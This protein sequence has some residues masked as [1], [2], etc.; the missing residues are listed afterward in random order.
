MAPV[1]FL[2]N[3]SY[4]G[5]RLNVSFISDRLMYTWYYLTGND[6]EGMHQLIARVS[7]GITS[8]SHDPLGVAEM[9]T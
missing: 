9:I 6:I 5:I 1:L 3:V 4:I 7:E 2:F 8:E